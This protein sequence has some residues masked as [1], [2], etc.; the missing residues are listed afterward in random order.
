VRQEIDRKKVVV[1]KNEHLVVTVHGIRTYGQWQSRLKDLLEQT[2]P[3]II[4]RNA[5]YGY[6]SILA[7]IFPPT[8]WLVTRRFRRQLLGVIKSNAW[9][10]V[11]LVGHSFGT[12]MLA[13]ALHGIAKE[14]T[15]R[16]HILILAGSVLKSNFR[17]DQF[18]GISVK[19]LINECGTRDG[20]LLLNQ[21]VV[22]F[23]GMA[24]RIGF[25]GMTGDNF[26][27]RYYQFG[28]S[29]YFLKGDKLDDQFMSQAWIPLLTTDT[30]IQEVDQ[31]EY[32]QGVRGVLT[33]IQLWV[34]NNA[35]PFKVTI[36][37]T[38]FALAFLYVL[39][40]YNNAEYQRRIA[41]SRQLIARSFLTAPTRLDRALLLSLAA[42]RVGDTAETRDTLL[43]LLQQV[44][45]ARISFLWGHQELVRN[46]GGRARVRSVAL[47]PDGKTVASASDDNTVIEWDATSRRQIGDPLRGHEAPV[48]SVTFSPDGRMLASADVNKTI[49]LWDANSRKPIGDPLRGHEGPINSVAFSADGKMLASGSDDQTV[50]LWDVAD[51]KPIGEPLRAHGGPVR[52]VTFAPIKNVL[53]SAG[54]DLT[55]MLWDA[56]SREPIGDPLRGHEGPINSV[57]FSA[58]GKM[59]ASG[60]DDQTVILW[61][62][63][64]RKPVVRLQGHQGSVSSVFFGTGDNVLASAGTDGRILVWDVA[65]RVRL[66]SAEGAKLKDVSI[67]G[68][69]GPVTSVS[70]SRD[71]KTIAAGAGQTVIL[72]DQANPL[73]IGAL[74]QVHQ[75]PANSVAFNADGKTFASAGDDGVMLWDLKSGKRIGDPRGGQGAVQG[76]AFSPD[77]K[78]LASMT[79]DKIILWETASPEPIGKILNEHQA[80][81]SRVGFGADSR[82]LVSI[83]EKG[84]VLWDLITL[85]P[86]GEPRPFKLYREY[87]QFKP[88]VSALSAHTNNFAIAGEGP[89]IL[90]FDMDGEQRADLVK[91]GQLAVT[92]LALSAD[93]KTLASGGWIQISRFGMWR[94]ASQ[95]GN[96]C[97]RIKTSYRRWPSAPTARCLRRPAQ[98]TV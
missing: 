31:R 45:P 83:T 65:S 68:Y 14:Q 52:S 36:W 26:Q 37:V 85:K 22:P 4:V 58:D 34:L 47:S 61:D 55:V 62:V 82:T 88:W 78:W 81:T 44:M 8:R 35:E 95:L 30:V 67:L 25:N 10:R 63:A 75:G 13:W 80:S 70:T 5:K 20:I 2:E 91:E 97:R 18:I 79:T 40:L 49:W 96:L 38:P 57:A 89:N 1:A 86:A 46:V 7:F 12:H 64:D 11:D 29:G 76:L 50:I 93:G 69:Q 53:A 84:I 72:Y 24:G 6:I 48:K 9:T 17:W 27:N 98:T 56:N 43:R 15:P 3:G 21:I 71:G 19:R 33:G 32:P 41:L 94:A 90:V 73:G 77:G 28:H 66:E 87:R 92:A 60:S 23:T 74:L 39:A 16:I 54:D 42:E 59:L 51:R